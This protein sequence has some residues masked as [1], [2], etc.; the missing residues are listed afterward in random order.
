MEQGCYMF[1]PFAT[2]AGRMHNVNR[3]QLHLFEIWYPFYYRNLWNKVFIVHQLCG[4]WLKIV[5]ISRS[6]ICKLWQGF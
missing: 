6:S 1:G 5:E 3:A 4:I 2:N